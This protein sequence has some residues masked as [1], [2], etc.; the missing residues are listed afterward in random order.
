MA[1]SLFQLLKSFHQIQDEQSIFPWFR[2]EI[3]SHCIGHSL[4]A[5]ICGLTGKMLNEQSAIPK[6]N[7][8]SGLDPAGPLFFNDA[9]FFQIHCA[10]CTEASRLNGTDAEIVD[11]IHTDGDPTYFGDIQVCKYVLIYDRYKPQCVEHESNKLQK[12]NMTNTIT[13]LKYVP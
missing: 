8:I 2:K 10:Q 13:A 12:K 5:H 11:V 9:S 7:R 4:G 6:W 3:Y 1:A